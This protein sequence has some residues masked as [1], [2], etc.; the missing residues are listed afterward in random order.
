MELCPHCHERYDD[1]NDTQPCCSCGHPISC[2]CHADF[3]EPV[4]EDFD[5][6]PATSRVFEQAE[7][8]HF[9]KELTR[10]VEK[11]ITKKDKG[12]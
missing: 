2:G 12:D 8:A 9:R 11:A 6:D 1:D 3:P 10:N 4:E 7:A 5:F